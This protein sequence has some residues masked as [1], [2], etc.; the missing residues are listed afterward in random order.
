MRFST[1]KVLSN[2]TPLINSLPSVHERYAYLA[3]LPSGFKQNNDLKE[4]KF[5]FS[6]NPTFT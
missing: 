4:L 1:T 2:N 5:I 3:A 6:C